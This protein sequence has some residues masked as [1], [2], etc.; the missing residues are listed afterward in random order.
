MEDT[1]WVMAIESEDNRTPADGDGCLV[2]ATLAGDDQAFG[3]LYDRH[4]RLIRAV[5][6]DTTGD[7]SQAEDLGQ[8][9]FLIA[10]KQLDQLRKP[11]QFAAWLAAIARH[12]CRRWLRRHSREAR[13]KIETDLADVRQPSSGDM[14]DGEDMMHLHSKLLELP[15]KER[16][17]IQICYLCGEGHEQA[18]AVLGLS[19]SGLYA[20]LERAK[21]RLRRLLAA[22]WKGAAR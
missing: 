21:Q 16:L 18:R 15:E 11:E 17:A 22:H 10:F 19:R 3:C 5:C 14:A 12:T 9:V 20:V 2:R 8:D 13:R 6:Y 7:V 4:A 1:I